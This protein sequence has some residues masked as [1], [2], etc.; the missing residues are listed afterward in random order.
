M[1]EKEIKFVSDFTLNKIKNLGSFITYEK[2][3][4]VDIH[5]AILRYISSELDFLIYEDRK[6]LLQQSVFDYS[7]DEINRLFIKINEQIKKTRKISF[8]DIKRLI[9]QAVS[10]NMNFISRPGWSLTKLV[11]DNSDSKP[12]DEIKIMLD[13]LYYYDYLKTI[14]LAYLNKRKIVTVTRIEFDLLLNKIDKEMYAP[15]QSKDLI[16]NAVYSIAEFFNIGGV[17]YAKVTP[18]PLEMFLK[19]KNQIDLLFR[20]RRALPQPVKGTFEVEELRNVMYSTR[21]LEQQAILKETT[22]PGPE[23]EPVE[24]P[25]LPLPQQPKSH[26]EQIISDLY[27]QVMDDNEPGI[28]NSPGIENAP[29]EVEIPH[30]E[31]E[32]LTEQLSEELPEIEELDEIHHETELTADEL[33]VD[34]PE[35]DDLLKMY[36]E[37]LKEFE[38]NSDDIKSD[39]DEIKFDISD[40]EKLESLYDFNESQPDAEA[41]EEELNETESKPEPAKQDEFIH[42]ED[43][44]YDSGL[45]DESLDDAMS[46]SFR[47]LE[48]PDDDM[49][50][51]IVPEDDSQDDF[52]ITD[53]IGKP[54]IIEEPLPEPESQHKDDIPQ[55]DEIEPQD[56][57]WTEP[58]SEPET[59]KEEPAAYSSNLP[60]EEIDPEPEPES[61]PERRKDLFKYLTNKEINKITD[62]IFN[63]DSEDFTSTIEK[64]SECRTYDEATE[65]LKGVFIANKINPY[66]RDAVTFTNAVSNYFNQ[67]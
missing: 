43:S 24:E 14:L 65:I 16:D 32:E 5:P 33:A 34:I 30:D 35:D 42:D 17:N 19:E 25:V 11:Y 66:S 20:L 6:K 18:V 2:L 13:Y 62:N 3:A 9:I 29:D 54:V 48:I 21:P 31:P 59:E 51:E 44:S 67:V 4:S 46:E 63:E 47:K 56:E 28:E 40:K 49:E 37:E 57:P 52:S 23:P 7:G 22:E 15:G 55:K 64:I 12:V 1:F 8:E 41:S 26:E 27:K 45:T 53:N 60:E 10:F 50:F 38:I 61:F 36:D 58:E 39:D